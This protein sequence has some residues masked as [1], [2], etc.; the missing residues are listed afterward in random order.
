MNSI[1]GKDNHPEIWEAHLEA[2]KRCYVNPSGWYRSEEDSQYPAKEIYRLVAERMA[3]ERD[4]VI[5]AAQKF[6]A[7]WGVTLLTPEQAQAEEHCCLGGYMRVERIDPGYARVTYI[8]GDYGVSARSPDGKSHYRNLHIFRRFYVCNARTGLRMSEKFYEA[9]K[10]AQ[11]I[12][13]RLP[14]YQGITMIVADDRALPWQIAPAAWAPFEQVKTLEE[15]V[16][17]ILEFPGD[18]CAERVFSLHPLAE[19]FAACAG[20]AY[21][22][23]NVMEHGVVVDNPKS[24]RGGTCD[25]F[26]WDHTSGLSV[27]GVTKNGLQWDTTKYTGKVTPRPLYYTRDDKDTVQMTLIRPED[28]GLAPTTL[29]ENNIPEPFVANGHRSFCGSINPQ[30]RIDEDLNTRWPLPWGFRWVNGSPKPNQTENYFRTLENAPEQLWLDCE[31]KAV[32]VGDKVQCRERGGFQNVEVREIASNS[33][34]TWVRGSWSDGR[35]LAVAEFLGEMPTVEDIAAHRKPG[36]P[37]WQG[38][39]TH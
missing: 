34:C 1:E 37:G 3:F 20:I 39:L 9:E 8:N 22:D 30:A 25:L 2:L 19:R 16:K 38:S 18:W 35:Y 7:K 13:E 32:K 10:A 17:A 33:S 11:T 14:Y 26:I 15:L 31:D 5:P 24:S 29:P 21:H 36:D 28:G 6:C 12:S 27:K 23:F 4:A